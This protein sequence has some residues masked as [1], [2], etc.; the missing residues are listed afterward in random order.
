VARADP[1]GPVGQ[2]Q[3][4]LEDRSRAQGALAGPVH[5]TELRR[6]GA[7]AD[8]P[9]QGQRGGPDLHRPARPGDRLLPDLPGRWPSRGPQDDGLVR[10]LGPG[11][12]RRPRGDRVRARLAGH[13]RL[14]GAV[15]A[16]RPAARARP[17]RGR[18]VEAAQRHD[19]HRGRRLGLGG[20]R[21]HREAAA[22]RRHREGARVHAQ[23]DPL[24][25]D[26]RE[27]PARARD[28]APHG[29]QALHHQHGRE[30]A[31]AGALQE[32]DRPLPPHLAAHHGLV[33]PG[34]ARPRPRPHDRDLPP[35]QGRR[36]PVDQPA[37]LRAELPAPADRVVHTTGADAR[38]LRDRLGEGP[39]GDGVR[40]LQELPAVGVQHPGASGPRCRRSC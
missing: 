25:L 32:V 21:A 6:Q 9:G 14:P 11:D 17:R 28:L 34:P 29:R 22:R 12:R 13:D 23:R 5:A 8:R 15:A 16:R 24:R 18:A 39:S 33:Q 35:R 37:R 7:P 4:D 1:L 20:G 40:P 36:V 31:R 30:R 38:P 19:L 3:P 27:H 26:R 2:G 10:R